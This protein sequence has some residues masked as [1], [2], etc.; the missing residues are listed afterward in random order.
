MHPHA[1]PETHTGHNK[2]MC[3]CVPEATFELCLDVPNGYRFSEFELQRNGCVVKLCDLDRDPKNIQ[4]TLVTKPF[5]FSLQGDFFKG[6]K[7]ATKI[8][9]LEAEIRIT[10]RSN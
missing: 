10:A 5:L 9:R 1:F 6:G 7:N 8:E 3:S 4:I 2:T